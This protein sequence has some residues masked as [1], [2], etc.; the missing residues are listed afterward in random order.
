MCAHT[1][2]RAPRGGTSHAMKLFPKRPSPAALGLALALTAGFGVS[3]ALRLRPP[4]GLQL[5]A[6]PVVRDV[7]GDDGSPAFG[8]QRP[9]VT[10]VVFTDYQCGVCKATDPALMRLLE[11]DP[12]VRVVFKDW[13]IR[14]P[15]SELAARTALAAHRQ[16][17]YLEV[18]KALMSA[19]GQLT[20]ERIEAIAEGAG[21]DLKRARRH[22]REIDAQIGRNS[23]Q[24]FGLGLQGTPGYIVGRFLVP[25]GLDD[26]NLAKVVER[27]RKAGPPAPPPE[28]T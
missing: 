18:H 8:A 1:L 19:R 2:R 26:R 5:T 12:T 4:D 13:P 17:R 9:E 15:G 21:V 14:G 25:G 28:D 27:A 24:A 7:L 23:T 10:I 16:G 3:A 20:R 11:T 6:T 22:A